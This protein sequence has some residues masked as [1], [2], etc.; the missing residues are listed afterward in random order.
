MKRR[1]LYAMLW[2]LAAAIV[3]IMG[4]LLTAEE[5]RANGGPPPSGQTTD[6]CSPVVLNQYAPSGGSPL[7]SG[8]IGVPAWIGNGDVKYTTTT[9]GETP[10]GKLIIQKTSTIIV[11]QWTTTC[12]LEETCSDTGSGNSPDTPGNGC[13][14]GGGGS[15]S[16]CVEAPPVNCVE[17]GAG[18][19][20]GG[21]N[22]GSGGSG[23]SGGGGMPENCITNASAGGNSGPVWRGDH[24]IDEAPTCD[25][26]QVSED[27]MSCMPNCSPTTFSGGV[28][29]LRVDRE[30][31][32]RG[33]V[34]VP[35]VFVL[36]GPFSK[37]SGTAGCEDP[38]GEFPLHT[39]RTMY[40]SWRMRS[41]IPPAWFFDERPWN[42]NRGV[43]DTAF[44][45]EVEHTYETASFSTF[46][47]DKPAVGPSTTG[48]LLP[49]Y[50]VRVDTWWDAYV[51]RE[52]DEYFWY[53]EFEDVDVFVPDDPAKPN[54]AGHW[55]T[56]QRV[57]PGFPEYRFLGHMAAEDKINLQQWQWPTSSLYSRHAWD[58]RMEGL[59]IPPQYICRYIPTP[60][61]E[62]QS[63]LTTSSGGVGP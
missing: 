18:G 12:A 54:W 37:D 8:R 22:G 52:W 26:V 1:I 35:N 44:G 33:L 55:E 3:A 53:Y 32:P 25:M 59:P 36:G 16:D 29:C 2:G 40:I 9:W 21:G 27:G 20:A 58:P 28:A 6:N 10:D 11:A 23:G 47:G 7:N 38:D 39:N 61:L 30:P 51:H 45:Y 60:I 41:D 19:G 50:M 62:S 48:E 46:E 15:G 34:S 14:T 56:Q 5:A 63:V 31:Y 24:N 42:I 57:K 13:N 4:S 17:S 49:A 43:P